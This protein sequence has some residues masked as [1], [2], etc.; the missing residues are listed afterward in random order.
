M[1]DSPSP[2][3]CLP[4][5]C[6]DAILCNQ[7]LFKLH[8]YPLVS[9]PNTLTWEASAAAQGYSLQGAVEARIEMARADVPA[10]D[11]WT[12]VRDYGPNLGAYIDDAQRQFGTSTNLHYRVL[13]RDSASTVVVSEAVRAHTHIPRGLST[14]YRE[15]IRR[16]NLRG[17]RGEIRKG[18]LLKKIRYGTRC[19]ECRDRDSGVSIIGQ[20][21]NCYGVGWVGGYWQAAGCSYAEFAPVSVGESFDE[22]SNFQDQGPST[23]LNLLN[24]PQLYSGDVWVEDATD[25]RWLIGELLHGQS[26]GS[27][28]LISKVQAH[29]IDLAHVAY[30]FPVE[31]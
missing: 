24:I 7:D 17:R 15:V 2:E 29:R 28:E 6:S 23:T 4:V 11:A 25:H 3:P 12:E 5:G 26:V 1:P 14:V 27:Q 31:R 8:V 20:C 10:A 9:G 21:L 19:T 18:Y 16:W 13:L 22:N 30:R